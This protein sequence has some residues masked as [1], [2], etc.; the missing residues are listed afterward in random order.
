MGGMHPWAS[1]VD[2]HVHD[3]AAI[4]KLADIAFEENEGPDETWISDSY[5]VGAMGE[6]QVIS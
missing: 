1:N 4:S 6:Q 3:S 5:L 2:T